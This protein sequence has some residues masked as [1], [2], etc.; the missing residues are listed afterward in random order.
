MRPHMNYAAAAQQASTMLAVCSGCPWIA[1]KWAYYQSAKCQGLAS[2]SWKLDD[3]RSAECWTMQRCWGILLHQCVA[4]WQDLRTVPLSERTTH[5]PASTMK[6]VS[7]GSPFL[8]TML[9][10]SICCGLRT[11]HS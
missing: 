9:P 2:S 5:V 4:T 1:K 10:A 7:P 8:M 6:N 11:A 3:S